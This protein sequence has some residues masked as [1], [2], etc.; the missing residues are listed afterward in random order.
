M[1][2]GKRIAVG[3]VARYCSVAELVRLLRA[4]IVLREL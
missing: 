4:A 1:N 2:S 3:R